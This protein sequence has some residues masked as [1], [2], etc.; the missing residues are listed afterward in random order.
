[1]LVVKVNWENYEYDIHSL[2]KAF[3][4]KADV[5][6]QV[7]DA[8]ETDCLLK[9]DV[10]IFPLF[11]QQDCYSQESKD[12]TLIPCPSQC[13]PWGWAQR[14]APEKTQVTDFFNTHMIVSWVLLGEVGS[15]V[16]QK[17]HRLGVRQM[18][19]KSLI[20]EPQFLRLRWGNMYA[21]HRITAEMK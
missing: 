10:H 12:R 13:P 14:P 11:P 6:V 9:M 21:P 15:L 4:P 7:K 18:L 3:Y 8:F 16:M 2:V 17:G 19:H 1:M 5:N 20:C